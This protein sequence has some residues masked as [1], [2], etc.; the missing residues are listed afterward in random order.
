MKEKKRKGCLKPILIIAVI[1][2]IIGAIMTSIEKPSSTPSSSSLAD[3]ME[4]TEQQESAILDL[5]NRCGIGE[6]TSV[7]KF[8]SGEEE[9]SY[10]VE[11]KITDNFNGTESAIV[12][13]LD[14]TTKEVNAIYFHDHDIFTDGQIVGNVSDYY[15][16]FE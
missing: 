10:H 9:T 1:F 8:Q 11:D 2:I 5:F 3:V 7:T 15:S 6:V 16:D 12:V 14:N 4:L 13:W